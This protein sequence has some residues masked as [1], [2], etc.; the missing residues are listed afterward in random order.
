MSMSNC[1]EKD[2]KISQTLKNIVRNHGVKYFYKGFLNSMVGTAIF[3]G[4]FNG[5][6]DSSK[7]RAKTLE[8]KAL[9]AYTCSLIA[10]GICYPLD[11]VRRRKIVTNSND[12]ILSYSKNILKTEGVRGFYKGSKLILP[13]SLSGAIILMLFDT[14]GIPIIQGV[15]E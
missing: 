9:I 2:T 14:A 8:F 10:G 1:T 3:R 13:Q 15:Q 5:L 7:S 11:S 4:S 6:Y 12:S